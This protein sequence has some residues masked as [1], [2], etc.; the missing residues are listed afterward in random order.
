[1]RNSPGVAPAVVEPQLSPRNMV[2]PNSQ[3]FVMPDTLHAI[4]PN[5]SVSL[6]EHRRDRP[7]TVMAILAGQRLDA[8]REVLLV[9]ELGGLIALGVR[10]ADSG[11]QLPRP[12]ASAPL[13]RQRRRG[14]CRCRAYSLRLDRVSRGS[15]G[16]TRYSNSPNDSRT[17]ASRSK[18]EL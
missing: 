6:I 5:T 11:R 7:V 18:L 14:T 13:V 12:S 9:V 15:I 4:L 16:E 1:M 3:A 2:G 8:L 10:L 17:D